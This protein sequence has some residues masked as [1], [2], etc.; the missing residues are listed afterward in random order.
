MIRFVLALTLLSGPAAASATTWTVATTGVDTPAGGTAQ[1]PWRTLQYAADR[2]APGDTVI[3]R[4]GTYRGFNLDADHGGTDG[5][6]VTFEADAGVVIDQGSVRRGDDG[7]NLEDAGWVVLDGFEVHGMTQAGIRAV[8][9][10]HC[11][12]VT[13]RNCWAHDNAVW[14]I[15]TSHCDDLLVEDNRAARSAEQ[16]GLYVSN[17][18][19]RPVVRRNELFDNH[20]C[21]LHMNGDQSEG[22][23]GLI[24]GA[25]V[26]DN[27]VHG[28]GAGGGGGAA[29]NGDGLQASIIQNNV[30]YD[31]HATG[32]A[33]FQIDAAAPAKDNVVV[34]NN[35]ILMASDA[36][37][38][39]GIK[40]GSTGNTVLNNV[41]Y[42]GNPS[43][44]SLELD[45]ASLPGLTSDYNVVVDRF[46]PDDG[47]TFQTLAQW[48]AQTH[49]DAHSFVAAPAALF[50]N[51]EAHD[52]RLTETSLARDKGTSSH[53]PAVDLAGTARA[54]PVDVGAYEYCTGTACGAG[55][56]GGGT[57]SGGKASG[58]CTS[59]AGG[60]VAILC[61][62]LAPMLLARRRRPAARAS[63]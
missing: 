12:H 26:E 54:A 49:Q 21:G 38:A 35:T 43:H 2:V 36:R 24:T 56:G 37:W 20:G 48:R 30:L 9:P 5:H 52:Y 18:C 28:N 16:H 62:T 8:G 40:N 41:L 6:P 13:I 22:G 59:G 11:K 42:D 60:A 23:N 44:G 17:A 14:G 32:I 58:G 31:N 27:L 10:D 45:T 34:N 51:A 39:V 47:D 7:I 19:V 1:A 63:R 55:G 46:T 50:V 3:V 25:L 4:A 33:L 61:A 29:I 15:F 57:P 53:A